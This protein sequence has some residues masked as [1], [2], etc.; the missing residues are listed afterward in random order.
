MNPVKT[1][2]SVYSWLIL[3]MLSLFLAGGDRPVEIAVWFYPI[4][5]LRFFRGVKWWKALIFSLPLMIIVSFV[6]NQGMTPI[7]FNILIMLTAIN[8]VIALIPYIVDQ[9]LYRSLPKYLK[10][11]LFPAAVVTAEVFLAS[12]FKG[13]TWGNPVYGINNLPLLQI[14]SIVGIWGLMFLIYWTA[15]VINE[16]WEHRSSLSNIRGFA[17]VFLVILI[18]IYGFGLWRLHNE[19]TEVNMVH[20]AGITSGVDYR[21]EMVEIL[22]KVFSANR[23]GTF[24]KEGIRTAGQKKYQELLSESEKLA[25]SGVEIVAWSEGAA[26]IFE[27]D[28]ELNIHQAIQSTKENK[29]YLALGILVLQD[30]CFELVAKNKPFLRNMLILIDPDG[31]VAWE[32]S[33]LN[34]APGYERIMTIPGDGTLKL[35]KTVKGTVTGVICYDMDFPDYI[36]QAG[37]MNSDL[38]I[39]PSFDWLEVKNIHAKMARLRAIENGISLLRPSN[40]GIS[41]AVDPY[42]NIMSSVDDIKSNASPLVS[43]LPVGSVKTLYSTLG[44]FWIWVCTIGGIF[45][46]ISGVLRVLK[47]KLLN[48][49]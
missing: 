3:A 35:S 7:P 45:L 38:L 17:I 10:T 37:V 41:T 48:K 40:S 43:V 33:K 15:S 39:A 23:T 19:K 26:F 27:S 25:Q 13:A 32:Y 16:V 6:S 14:V 49:R 12:A 31:N 11:L 29:Y 20:V 8:S 9:L 22:G 2:F 5:L 46:I 47:Q 4:F 1:S 28:K 44:D 36:R 18:V 30:N 24:D 21:T 42:G 34:L